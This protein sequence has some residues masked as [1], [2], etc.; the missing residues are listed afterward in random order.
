[1]A[2]TC[3]I[4]GKGPHVGHTVTRRGVAKKK[5][6]VGIKIVR[7]NPRRFLPN[8]QRVKARIAGVVRTIR[9]CTQCIKSG[10]VTKA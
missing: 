1:M 9:V 3:A 4:C 6:G 2:R 5:G 7:V 10:L 8:L